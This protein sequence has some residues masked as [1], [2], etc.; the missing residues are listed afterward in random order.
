M[1]KRITIAA[2]A[3][4]L[5]AGVASAE[6]N[7]N[8]NGAAVGK[9]GFLLN[10]HAYDQ[11][12]GGDFLDSNRRQIAVQN[13]AAG[14]GADKTVK[15]NKI[16]LQPGEDFW[17]Q[18]GNACDDGANFYLPITAENCSNCGIE[19]GDPVDPTFTQYE[20]RARVLGQPGGSV[21]VTSCVEE[22]ADDAIVVDDNTDSEILC[23]VGEGNIWVQTRTVGNGKE[24]NKWENVSTQLLTVC[25]D[26]DGDMACDD[27]LGLFDP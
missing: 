1:E 8:G 20:V 16:F 7:G 24:Q 6:P 26:T 3:A 23:S 10:V 27:R 25:V 9:G 21:N 2:I 5:A 11:C 14:N 13:G 19:E 18:D 12:P 17:V 22:A 15:I 4:I